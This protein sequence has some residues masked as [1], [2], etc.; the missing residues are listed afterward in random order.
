MFMT[1]LQK[2]VAGLLALTFPCQLL[3]ATE[4]PPTPKSALDA[5]AEKMPVGTWAELLSKN[6]D[7][8]L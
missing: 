7:P 6:I 2:A 5:L 3:G 1:K 8:V 4:Q